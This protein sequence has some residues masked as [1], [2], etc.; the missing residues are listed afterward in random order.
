[1]KLKY[2]AYKCNMKGIGYV[3]ESWSGSSQVVSWD[4]YKLLISRIPKYY[5]SIHVL[6]GDHNIYLEWPW[7]ALMLGLNGL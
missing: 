2:M 3:N 1:M 5:M 7:K 4:V 6:W